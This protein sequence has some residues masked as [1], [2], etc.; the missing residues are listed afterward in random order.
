MKLNINKVK[1]IPRG[2]NFGFCVYGEPS[3]EILD[4]ATHWSLFIEKV[5]PY[6]NITPSKDT[7]IFEIFETPKVYEY[8]D[9]FS[10]NLNK[11]LHLGHLSNLIIAKCLQ[12]LG[13]SKKTLAILGDTLEGDVNKEDALTKY[14][15]YCSQFGYTLD[16]LFFASEQKLPENLE[17]ILSDG[18]GEYEGTKIFN[19]GE[20]IVG[21]KSDGS[22]S[23]FYQDIA[24]AAKL[25]A[26]TLYI[27]GLEQNPHFENVRYYYPNNKHIGLGL[28]TVNGEKM[29]SSKG[30]VIFMDNILNLVKEKFNDAKLAWNVLAGFILKYD[31]PSMKN[32]DMDQIDNVKLSHGL[33]LSYTLARLKSAGMTPNNIDMFISKNLQFRLLKAKTSLQPNFLFEEMIEHCKV[34]NKMYIDYH[35][36]DNIENQQ[37]FQ[38]LMDDLLFGMK[39]LGMFEIDKV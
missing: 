39:S 2:L 8:G 9:F 18:D 26:P 31:L 28:V 21:I 33:Y 1:L 34:I 12:S 37:K 4:W 22:T 20:K 19:M 23:Y 7:N 15:E 32:I 38:P 6:T 35:I 25:R 30:N 29:S 27:T 14:N 17:W 36:K 10:P 11:H 24:L 5:G 16:D 3:Q 13:V